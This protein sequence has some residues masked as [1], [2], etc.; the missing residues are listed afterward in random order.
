MVLSTIYLIVYFTKKNDLSYVV[1]YYL[2]VNIIEWKIL[3]LIYTYIAALK[4]NF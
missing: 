2:K 1:V 4:D 3:I